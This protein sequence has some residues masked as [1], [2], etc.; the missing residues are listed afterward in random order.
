MPK[1]S[2]PHFPRKY[3]FSE[4]GSPKR[5]T[6]RR[7]PHKYILFLLP[8]ILQSYFSRL[9]PVRLSPHYIP[10]RCPFF[11]CFK[12]CALPTAPLAGRPLFRQRPLLL[13]TYT[14]L[15]AAAAV[16]HAIWRLNPPV[17]A[18]RSSTSPIKYSPFIFFDS[19]VPGSISFTLTPPFVMM[20]SL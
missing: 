8:L 6:S 3:S 12:L 16:D 4:N 5:G 20:A 7:C 14:A 15:P 1:R 19:I 2:A 10:L 11:L 18:S 9:L 17:S 13:L